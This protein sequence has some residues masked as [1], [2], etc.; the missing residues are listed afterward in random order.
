MWQERI[1]YIIIT[2]I[3][4]TSYSIQAFIFIKI[5]VKVGVWRFRRY[6]RK[7]RAEEN[8]RFWEAVKEF[9]SLPD[10]TP[11]TNDK[12]KHIQRQFLGHDCPYE[13]HVPAAML[14]E[15]GSKLEHESKIKTDLFDEAL[16][17]IEVV[18]RN[19]PYYR[20][21]KSSDYRD[22]LKWL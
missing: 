21:L 11:E 3:S 14:A 22:L 16:K 19:D 12:A 2:I 7:V 8:L 20:F 4:I 5:L 9:K 17:C 13:V 6:L 10:G 18:L 15:I 1:N